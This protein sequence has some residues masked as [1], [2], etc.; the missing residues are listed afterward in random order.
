MVTDLPQAQA[1]KALRDAGFTN[2]TIQMAFDPTK[3]AGTVLNQSPTANTSGDVSKP[4]V[5][6][7][8]QGPSPSPTPSP[9]ASDT[10]SPTTSPTPSASTSPT[11]APTL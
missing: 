5:L 7:I 10:G 3:P 2:I 4:V 11:V 9:S 1:E 8:S 6:T